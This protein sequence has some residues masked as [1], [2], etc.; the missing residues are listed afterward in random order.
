MNGAPS[1]P[2][3]RPALGITF[4][5]CGLLFFAVQDAIVKGLVDDYSVPQLLM[6]RSLVAAPLLAIMV[7]YSGG[8]AGFR[9]PQLTLHLIRAA[10]VIIAFMSYY[11]A[12]A[13]IALVDVVAL[14]STAPLLITALAAW[15]LRERVGTRRWLAVGV[16]FV[17]VVVMLQPG[18]GV[19]EPIAGLGLVAAGAYACAALIARRLGSGESSVLIAF[20]GNTAFLLVCGTLLASST[21]M[22]KVAGVTLPDTP[23]LGSYVHAPPGEMLVMLATGLVSLSGFVLVPRAYQVAPASTISPFEY[24]Y[25]LWALLIGWLFFAEIP[26]GATLVGAALVVSAGIYVSRLKQH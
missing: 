14:F 17:G 7:F 25:L 8:L 5:C 1:S 21:W 3:E 15:L 2:A 18:S 22:E 26:S 19:V 16:G 24:T 11:T 20:Y 23:L 9:S 13:A 12:V 6:M 4:L 10:L